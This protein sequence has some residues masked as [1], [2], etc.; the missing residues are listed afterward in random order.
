VLRERGVAAH[1]DFVCNAGGVLGYE[2]AATATPA[3]VL[4]GVESRIRGLVRAAAD[5]PEGPFAGA[6]AIAE[7]F[8]GSWLDPQALP[9][10]PP[11]A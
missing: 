3:E 6:C 5:H 7:R 2:S 10:G 8:L 9:D 4:A 1:G 11:L